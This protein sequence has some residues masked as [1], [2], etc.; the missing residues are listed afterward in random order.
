MKAREAKFYFFEQSSE[1]LNTLS[2]IETN[3][4]IPKSWQ[5]FKN[6]KWENISIPFF[7]TGCPYLNLKTSFNIDSASIGKK[8]YIEFQGTGG[9]AEVY[10]NQKLLQFIPNAQIPVKIAIVN[11]LLLYEQKNEITIN[12][13]IPKSINEGYPVFTHLYTEPYYL[14]IINPIKIGIEPDFFIENLTYQVNKVDEICEI[15]YAYD[16]NIPQKLIDQVIPASIDYSILGSQGKLYHRRI[17][18]IKAASS[19]I[20][21]LLKISKTELWQP[22]NP[23]NS[24]LIYT[25]ARNNR[26][27][28]KDTLAFAFRTSSSNKKQFFL[29]GDRIIIKG[30]NYYQNYLNFMGKD[31]RKIIHK[32]LKNIKNLGFN[33]VRFPDYFPDE[34]II[35][36]ADSIGLLLFP[37]LP[38]RR[39]PVSLFQSDN[40]LENTK[41]SIKE[42]SNFIYKHPAFYAL[43]LGQEIPLYHGSVQKFYLIINGYSKSITLLPTYLSPILSNVSYRER[44]ADFYILDIYRPLHSIQNKNYLSPYSLAGKVAIIRD[45]EAKKW[46]TEPSNLKRAIFL[47]QEIQSLFKDFGFKGGFIESYQDWYSIVPTNLTT[48]QDNPLIM[49]NGIMQ[50]NSEPKPWLNTI[51]NIWELFNKMTI[52]EHSTKTATNFFS[53]LMLF[54]SL[55]FLAIYRKQSRL[56][57]NLKRAVR[58]PYG[59]FVDLRERRIIPLFNSF[60]VGAFAALILAVYLGSFFYY[61]RDSFWIQEIFCLFLK[62]FNLYKDYLEY[63]SS[64]V[65]ITLVFFIL[66]FLYPILVSI[67]LYLINIFNVRKIRYRQGL[68]IA[69]WS[70]VPLFF[71]LPISLIGYHLLYYLKDQIILF[72]IMGVF[73]IWSHLRIVNGIRVLFITKSAK[74]FTILLLSY[75]VPILIFWAVFRP[76]SH[77]YDYFILLLNTKSLF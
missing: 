57:D 29:N 39:Y 47:T 27:L 69:L 32:D 71:L 40:L 60:L 68:A 4:I 21:G 34:D 6:G 18:T 2:K 3:T 44:F 76:E 24:Y 64:P 8:I 15:N 46:D 9:S 67:I 7:C 52:G 5:V 30:I 36:M 62:P 41:R 43:G 56:R 66:L 17:N 73:I 48:K 20:E 23:I 12:F 10:L 22:D 28:F 65:K 50:N 1:K 53:I 16:L 74:I 26:I 54:A 31:Y 37:E 51:D 19:T 13:R 77:W 59:F 38:I 25:I 33:A 11:D 72:I 55:I 35:F 63:V 58:H 42:I 14:G 45:S 61:Y 70:G 75:I 49:P